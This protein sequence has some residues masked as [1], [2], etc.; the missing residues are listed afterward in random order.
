[1]SKSK[2][3]LLLVSPLPP[4]PGGIAVWTKI[5]QQRGIGDGWR[6]SIVNS[7]L[8]GKTVADSRRSLVIEVTRTVK[9]LLALIK[10]LVFDPPSVVHINSSLSERGVFRDALVV[11]VARL[12]RASVVVNLRGNF[13]PGKTVG[14]SSRTES[15]YRF[16]FSR[17][18]VVVVLNH[19]S[20]EGVFE[21]GSFDR[22]TIVMP[23]FVDI[24]NIPERSSTKNKIFKIAYSGAL[25]ESKG[26][27]T[28][29]EVA[30]QL[31]EIEFI[32]IGDAPADSRSLGLVNLIQELPNVLMTGSLPHNLA[33]Q[34]V[35][36][37]DLLFH[38][39]HTEGFPLAIAEAMAIGLPVVAS[40]VG[41]IVDMIDTP[42]G[43]FLFPAEASGDYVTALRALANDRE[44]SN[45]LGEYNRQKSRANYAFEQVIERW[46]NIY[47]STS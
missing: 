15:I 45:K 37:C 19:Q 14:L 2:R 27:R 11:T 33:L 16:I 20:K 5:I 21:L 22:K 3:H 8:I 30:A 38:P 31:P 24:Q 28:I 6:T 47:K 41:A 29:F 35:S 13:I 42:Q 18:Q 4:P 43:G 34:T 39:S 26:L 7:G 1:M 44:M 17:S 36:Q 40:P 32:L 23:N 9:I 10:I 12:F 46:R 25:I